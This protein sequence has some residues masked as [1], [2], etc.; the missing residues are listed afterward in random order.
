MPVGQ[1]LQHDPAKRKETP[2]TPDT[3]RPR[4]RVNN[5]GAVRDENERLRASVDRLEAENAA[6]RAENVRLKAFASSI[7]QQA[8]TVSDLTGPR[9]M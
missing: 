6:L 3:P 1:E 9:L 4:K 8:A 5:A 2:D 7:T